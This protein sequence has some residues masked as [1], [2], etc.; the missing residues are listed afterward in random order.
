MLE[1]ETSKGRRLNS[2]E[3]ED[4]EITDTT[5][6]KKATPVSIDWR[7]AN[8]V[9][10]IKNEGACSASWSF[11]SIASMESKFMI[12]IN[13]GKFQSVQIPDNNSNGYL[14]FSEQ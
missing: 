5:E 11:S 8:S 6:D 14:I 4:E 10:P 7:I 13:A 2:E 9:S 1:E 12:D 3:D